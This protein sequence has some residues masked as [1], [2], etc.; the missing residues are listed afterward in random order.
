[1]HFRY[2]SRVAGM[3]SSAIRE[4]LKITQQPDIISFAGG[5]PAP[6]TFPVKELQEAFNHVL[7]EQGAAALQYGVS[8]GYAPLRAWVA[9]R[10]NG[11]GIDCKPENIF[12]S[13]GSQQVLD[14]AGKIF[15]DPGDKVIVESPVYLAAVQAF[16]TYQAEFVAVPADNQG[17]DTTAL[18]QKVAEHKPKL[19]YINPTFENPRGATL[20]ADRR[21]KIAQIA[22]AYQVPV[23]EDDPY[24]ELRFDGEPLPPIKSFPGGEWIIHMSSFS[25]IISPG[26]RVGWAVADAD[27]I[28]KLTM[29]KQASDVHTNSLAQCGIHRYLTTN[30]L[31]AHISRITDTYRVQRDTMLAEMAAHFPAACQWRK[32]EGGMFIWVTLPEGSDATALLAKA[33]AEKVA[34]VPGAPFYAGD[35]VDKNTLRL[36]FSNSSPEQI[37]TGIRRLGAIL[38]QELL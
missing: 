31:D 7:S 5:M 3:Q 13:A 11:K 35:R 32:P 8:E 30:D 17:M 27:V 9:E 26:L 21:A 37:R 38:R 2:A 34:F 1:M 15:L 16:R 33:V 10:M 12:I 29:S 20:P 24:G 19:I 14:F 4:I 22:A 25:K 36:N 6:S 18:E 23:I 28:L